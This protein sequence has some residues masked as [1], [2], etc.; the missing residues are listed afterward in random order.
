M[1]EVKEK[2]IT[3]ATIEAKALHALLS[4]ALT[5]AH[6]GDDL[7]RLNGVYLSREEGRIVARATDRYRLI[8]GSI[9]SEGEGESTPIRLSYDDAKALI[10]TLSKEKRG[11]V[12]LTLAGDLVSVV[13]GG[14][15]LTYTAHADEFPPHAHLFPN[16]TMKP[17]DFPYVSFNPIFFADYG[18][19]AG[20]KA[21]VIIRQ[22]QAD[23]AYEVILEGDL[24]G[25]EWKALLMPMK[26]RS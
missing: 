18:K 17:I 14:S 5:H 19:I 25:V 8:V 11:K 26:V 21:Q 3:S 16:E 23:R 20:K 12:E 6:K 9:E 7:P 2:T 15:T 24:Q 13:V 10:S 22:Y 1:N 4:G